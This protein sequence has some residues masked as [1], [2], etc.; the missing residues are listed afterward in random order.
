MMAVAARWKT[1]KKIEK[2]T[3][4]SFSK[5]RDVLCVFIVMLDQTTMM[6]FN[7]F[8][9]SFKFG[10]IADFHRFCPQQLS[11]SVFIYDVLI[12]YNSSK[13]LMLVLIFVL[14]SL[15]QV[16]IERVD[17][18]QSENI[19]NSFRTNKMNNQKAFPLSF[20]IAHSNQFFLFID[21]SNKFLR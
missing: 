2:S 11:N 16:R 3:L 15:W 10:L 6:D 1:K 14:F 12:L 4:E 21:N 13:C 20:S 17:T 7:L 18:F 9:H 5:K 8:N 19:F